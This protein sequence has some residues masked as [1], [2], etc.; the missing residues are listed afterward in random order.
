MLALTGLAGES[1]LVTQL[2][3][4]RVPIRRVTDVVELLAL[5]QPGL[6]E[7]LLVSARFPQMTR[8]VAFRISRR[9]MPVWG[10]ADPGDDVAERTLSLIHI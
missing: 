7:G 6:T 5:A 10:L 4:Q 3:G 1:A 2:A 9:G 8:D